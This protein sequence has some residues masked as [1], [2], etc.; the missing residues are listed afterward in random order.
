MRIQVIQSEDCCPLTNIFDV[1]FNDESKVR[2][3]ENIKCVKDSSPKEIDQ[4]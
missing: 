2:V 4:R 3:N 1:L